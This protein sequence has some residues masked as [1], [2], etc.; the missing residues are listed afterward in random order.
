MN[1]HF[2]LIH[3]SDSAWH[4]RFFDFVAS[5]FKGGH[6]FF[7]WG[8]RGG[9]VDGYEVFAI[10][11]DNQIVSTVGRQSM[12][13]VINGEARNGY[14]LGAVATHANHRNHG[15]ARLLMKKVLSQLDAPDQPVILFANPSVLDFYPRFGFR[16]L[17]Q[18][19]FVGHTDLRPAGPLAPRL[20]LAR[21]TDRAWLADHCAKANFV[22]Q[23]FAARDYYPILLF[24]L[25]RQPR[26]AF[27]LDSFGAVVVAQQDGE[28]LLIED[29]L[30]IRPF[31]LRDALPHVCAQPV[32]TIEF[33]FH[34]E[35]WWPDAESQ[36]L[37]DDG[38]PL[39]ARGTATQ[40]KEPVRFPDLA[41]T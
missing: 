16:R 8:A 30:A 27:K 4:D 13:Y 3:H 31:S 22:G 26:I 21:P 7:D 20:D 15:L 1:E 39:F 28:R 34:P 33:G 14:Q 35:A 5:I 24:H 29:L 41:Q 11:V 9:W 10:V 18:T 32:R 37:D 25:T 40:V 6:T 12:R 2:R 17:V 23:G 38:S 36:V 19:G